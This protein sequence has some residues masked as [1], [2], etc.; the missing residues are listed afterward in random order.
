MLEMSLRYSFACVVSRN[1]RETIV[2][3]NDLKCVGIMSCSCTN[4]FILDRVKYVIF[5]M[6]SDIIIP[7]VI[8]QSSLYTARLHYV[9]EQML[10]K[11]CSNY[12]NWIVPV[13]NISP[14]E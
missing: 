12:F 7:Y 10:L 2:F 6:I 14:I 3:V 5:I 11:L 9:F 1:Y 4:W 8:K 13:E